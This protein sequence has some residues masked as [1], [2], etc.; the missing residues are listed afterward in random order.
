MDRNEA[1][2]VLIGMAVCA[3]PKLHC[4]EDC[5]FYKEDED[6]KYINNEFEL[7]Q[8]VKILKEENKGE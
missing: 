7:V 3:E 2:K 4:D 1:I 8:A 5:P 6:C